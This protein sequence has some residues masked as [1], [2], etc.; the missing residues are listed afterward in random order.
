MKKKPGIFD[1]WRQQTQPPP[2]APSGQEDGDERRLEERC[3]T[4]AGKRAG[5]NVWV[6]AA[7]A[8]PE[9][10]ALTAVQSLLEG[11]R[12]IK[13]PAVQAS[14]QKYGLETPVSSVDAERAAMAIRRALVVSPAAAALI[15]QKRVKAF[16][17]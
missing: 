1:P 12:R 11:L 8:D 4:Y 16:V 10:T 17:Q 3:I 15:A 2:A 7:D 6:D 9:H 5:I 13:D 14:L